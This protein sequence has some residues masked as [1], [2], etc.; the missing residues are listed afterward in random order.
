ME[1][2]AQVK[3]SKNQPAFSV[4]RVVYERGFQQAKDPYIEE[5]TIHFDLNESFGHDRGEG[6]DDPI[7]PGP[8]MV[9]VV[10]KLQGRQGPDAV[11]TV[12]VQ[13]EAKYNVFF[14]VRRSLKGKAANRV[15][16]KAAERAY[17]RFQDLVAQTLESMGLPVVKPPLRPEPT[18]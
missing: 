1:G 11:R 2:V 18:P 7:T 8:F 14:Q 15:F 16:R 4:E 6:E 3:S 13:L 5:M 9:Q 10:W 12:A 17:P